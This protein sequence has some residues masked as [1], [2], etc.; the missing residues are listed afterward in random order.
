MGRMKVFPLITLIRVVRHR[1]IRFR[2]RR[3][4][5]RPARRRLQELKGPTHDVERLAAVL[6]DPEMGRFDV[7]RLVDR[8][9]LE[10][11]MAVEGALRRASPGDLVVVYYAGHG[12]LA[13]D[14]QL[15]LCALDT[16]TEYLE[17]TSLPLPVVERL[18][19]ASRTDQVALVLDCCR[20]RMEQAGRR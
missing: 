9:S 2:E 15:C 16:T 14:N 7:Q 4:L 13:F 20:A 6:A 11:R 17:S 3:R 8:P 10:L 1:Q 19:K 18:I 12:K 5:P